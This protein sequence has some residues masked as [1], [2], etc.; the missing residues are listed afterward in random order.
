MLIEIFSKALKKRKK[1]KKILLL[2]FTY[3]KDKESFI[4]NEMIKGLRSCCFI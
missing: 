2:L 3:A 1:E 4:T